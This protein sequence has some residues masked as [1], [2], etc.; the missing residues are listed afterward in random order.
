[1]PERGRDSMGVPVIDL[2]MSL[3]DRGHMGLGLV[4]SGS[5]GKIRYP[6]TIWTDFG[7]KC[8]MKVSSS[9]MMSF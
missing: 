5:R 3:D 4:V 8:D 7:E 2:C 6:R 9:L 1:M